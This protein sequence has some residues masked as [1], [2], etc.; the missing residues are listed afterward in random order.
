MPSKPCPF[1]RASRTFEVVVLLL[2]LW[3]AAAPAEDLPT[4][5]GRPASVPSA[6]APTTRVGSLTPDVDY[7]DASNTIRSAYFR[8]LTVSPHDP[9]V[10]YLA[11]YDGY[12]WKTVDG[13]KTWDESRLIL[14]TRPFYGDFGERVYFGVHRLDAP[15]WGTV[16]A[17]TG[18]APT[19]P[20]LGSSTL[21]GTR[22][23]AVGDH[24]KK[25]RKSKMNLSQMRLEPIGP[26][27][28]GG[29][30]GN[31]NFGIGLPGGAPRLQLIVRKF[32][33]PTSGINIKQTLLMRGTRP[34]EVRPIVVHPRNPKIVFAPTQFGLFKSYD[35][36]LIWVRTFQGDN[37]AGRSILTVAVHPVNDQ[38][39][40]VGTGDG[41]YISKDGGENFARS[42]SQGVGSGS[43]NWLAFHP[44]DAKYV[45]AATDYGL[46]RSKDGGQDWD[47][48]YFTT[49]PA[50]RIVRYV[51]LDAFDPKVG[52]IATLDGLFASTDIL[53]GGTD[54]WHRL[55][56]LAL[57]GNEAIRIRACPKHKGHLWTVTN[58]K[59]PSVNA[60]G[61]WDTGGAF[62][63]ESVDGGETWKVIYSG[64][65]YGSM[66][67]FDSHASDP[68]L[69]WM[70]WSRAVTR[71]Q[72]FTRET[73]EKRVSARTRAE[74]DRL[75]G[76]ETA[77]SLSDVLLA[78]HRYTGTELNAILRY[79]RR[80]MFKALV[81]RLDFSYT[82]LRQSEYPR[83]L[84]GLYWTLPFFRREFL[85]GRFHDVRAVASWDLSDMVFNLNAW[86][87]GRMDRVNYE[88]SSYVR[89]AV[90]RFYGE[91]QRLRTSMLI[92]PPKELRVRLAYKLRLEELESYLNFVT[93]GYL[94]RYQRGGRPS[95]MD[96]K[97]FEPWE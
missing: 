11:S 30:L 3:P 41:M 71:M 27:G 40:F 97:V 89:L 91:W 67:W 25:Y 16:H 12:V 60:P 33:K 93:G 38:M 47:W 58:T 2:G 44:R 73:R 20:L 83:V 56:G 34:T 43:V 9:K 78:A 51:E 80:S 55:G 24:E 61:Y 64:V 92:D 17:S 37:P 13:G 94:A 87:F 31:T 88:V 77:P 85:T 7:V 65:T 21:A 5:P 19:R 63:W 42:P 90:H 53:K 23:A 45:Y 72:R 15:D 52:Y 4:L 62:I 22:E 54:D 18:L 74:V 79:R 6:P 39:V 26:G 66:Q 57:T 49:Y 69:L 96:T 86:L 76:G 10:A 95:G 68:D 35:G 46:L 48:I 50:A 32:G 59:I 14:E 81:P 82:Y 29:G 84:E 36:G 75:L 70:I 1:R 8:A 28:G